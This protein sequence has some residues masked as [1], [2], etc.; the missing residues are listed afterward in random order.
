VNVTGPAHGGGTA[1]AGQAAIPSAPG[2]E[3]QL[4]SPHGLSG[5]GEIRH[6]AAGWRHLLSRGREAWSG[7]VLDELGDRHA[8]RDQ[9]LHPPRTG[10]LYA[11]AASTF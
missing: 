6:P 2:R 3:P 7:W 8:D 1:R 4:F 9:R 10:A 5:S 11:P